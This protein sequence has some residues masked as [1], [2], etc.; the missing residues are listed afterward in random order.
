MWTKAKNQYK[1][2]KTTTPLFRPRRTRRTDQSRETIPDVQDL[3]HVEHLC[4]APNALQSTKTVDVR[5]KKITNCRTTIL[6]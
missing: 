2:T 6:L 3:K 1:K 5:I 4:N